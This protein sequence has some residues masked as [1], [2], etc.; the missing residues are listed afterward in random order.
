MAPATLTLGKERQE[1]LFCMGGDSEPRYVANK[2]SFIVQVRG[3]SRIC[4]KERDGG[5]DGKI[6]WYESFS[7]SGR[8]HL[9]AGTM[10]PR[11]S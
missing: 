10:S 9:H 7:S 2:V 8:R 5:F 11:E 4:F 6:E 1:V 3:P